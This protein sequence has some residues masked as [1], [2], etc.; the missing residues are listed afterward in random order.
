MAEANSPIFKLKRYRTFQIPRRRIA[1]ASR[2]RASASAALHAASGWSAAS[3]FAF[4]ASTYPSTLV[5]SSIA[6]TFGGFPMSCLSVFFGYLENT[7]RSNSSPNSCSSPSGG[8]SLANRSSHFSLRASSR[9]RYL[10][11][12]IPQL[13]PCWSLMRCSLRGSIYG[14]FAL[15]RIDLDR[16]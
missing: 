12:A 16:P 7:I 9:L 14:L 2:P 6:G 8:C 1:P 3:M 5:N 10:P 4:P 15:R 11:R 13:S